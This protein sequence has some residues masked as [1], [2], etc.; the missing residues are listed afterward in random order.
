MENTHEEANSNVAPK[1]VTGATDAGAA[2]IGVTTSNDHSQAT[3]VSE[4]QSSETVKKTTTEGGGGLETITTTTITTTSKLV[5]TKVPFEESPQNENGDSEAE[6]INTKD[7][8]QIFLVPVD[9]EGS[10][11]QSAENEELDDEEIEIEEEIEVD[12]TASMESGSQAGTG[13]LKKKKKLRIFKKIKR[14][15]KAVGKLVIKH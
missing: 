12:D 11:A 8:P 1:D 7:T 13:E 2:P 4:H 15:T 6:S 9:L 14:G 5:T 3:L 10:F